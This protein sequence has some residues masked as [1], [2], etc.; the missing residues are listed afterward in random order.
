MHRLD[1]LVRYI[2]VCLG[3]TGLLYFPALIARVPVPVL[4]AL[5]AIS[6]FLA[7]R[8]LRNGDD[9][10]HEIR[11]AGQ[12]WLIWAGLLAGVFLITNRCI[13]VLE[14]HGGWDAW[15][16]WNYMSK[17]LSMPD[18]WSVYLRNQMYNHNDYP[19]MLPG[20][21][22][23]MIRT[24]GMPY[25]E[26]VVF[27]VAFLFTL[28]IPLW[29]YTRLGQRNVWVALV[30]LLAFATDDYYL[31]NGTSQYADILV[32]FFFLATL[33]T[34][35]R[36]ERPEAAREQQKLL[37]QA[38]IFAG[39]GMWSKNEGVILCV[40]TLLVW[41]VP[42]WRSKQLRYL[43]AGLLLPAIVWTW[44]RL[45]WPAENDM[46]AG[47]ASQ[48]MLEKIAAPGR[49][50]MIWQEL[51]KLL[52]GRFLWSQ[53]AF[54]VLTGGWLARRKLP[55]RSLFLVLLAAVVYNLIYVITPSDLAWHLDTSQGR[56]MFQLLPAFAYTAGR[57]FCI[58]LDRS[59]EPG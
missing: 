47:Q 13:Y 21:N 18:Y 36:W 41:I 57:E 17:A 23:L 40:L 10:Q 22:A 3:L 31:F 46:I 48:N 27:C 19:L 54:L 26:T 2:A 45:G 28:L 39:C 11:P 16:M 50:A 14:L 5:M 59:G 9:S 53:L 58:V 42:I 51:S 37:V 20:I 32:G 35:E 43:L 12:R 29:I 30:A 8:L 6:Y 4:W 55:H 34:L 24:V 52:S 25:Y 33:M 15:A 38:G 1:R 56:L 49:Y 44:F 7:W